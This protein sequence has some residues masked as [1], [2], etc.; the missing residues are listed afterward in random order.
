VGVHEAQAAEPSLGGA[1][2]ADVGQ[3]ELA[4]VA[5]D[6]GVDLAGAMDEDAHLTA[7]LER[8]ASQGTSQF[9]RGDVVERDAAPVEA[10]E[11][12]QRRGGQA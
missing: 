12:V 11:G 9:R 6:D 8:D 3:I 5:D 2:A 7:R 1:Q 10:L 4:G